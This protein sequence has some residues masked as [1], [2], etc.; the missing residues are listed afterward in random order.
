MRRHLYETGQ[1]KSI[2]G[3]ELKGLTSSLYTDSDFRAGPLVC[4]SRERD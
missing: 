1:T 2:C 4:S 3:R